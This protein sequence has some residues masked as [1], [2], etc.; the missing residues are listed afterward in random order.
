MSRFVTSRIPSAGLS[1]WAPPWL[2]YQLRRRPLEFL[3]EQESRHPIVRLGWAGAPLY[4][5]SA[6][7]LVKEMLNDTDHFVKG[8][9]LKKL[10]I[11]IGQGLITLNGDAWREG[12]RRVQKVFTRGILPQQHQT[13]IAHTNRMIER[14]KR[15]GQSVVNLDRVM[16]ELTF[17]IALDLFLGAGEET[18][19]DMDQLQWAIDNLNAYAKW[20]TWSFIPPHWKTKRNQEFRRALGIL[21]DVV[22]NVL[23]IRMAESS[24][25]QAGR[26]DVF[27]LLRQAGFEGRPLRDHIM[28]ILI[29]G[30]E[31]TGTSLSFLWAHVRDRQDLQE[32]L[33]AEFSEQN[34]VDL[35]LPLAEAIW[36]ETLRLYPAVPILDR[37]AVSDVQLGEHRIPR[38]SNV[39]WSPYVVQRSPRYWPQ[40]RDPNEFDP[41]AFLESPVPTPGSFI[42]FGEGPRMCLGKAFADMEA[43]T[44]IS[45]FAQAFEMESIKPGPIEMDTLVTLRPRGGVHVRLRRRYPQEEGMAGMDEASEALAAACS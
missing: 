12:R 26:S 29:A 6:P 22:A 28:T 20:R 41:V 33:V 16:N 2:L 21:D 44:I 38:G 14:L 24:A 8:A 27:S 36:K 11:I 37:T 23:R 32:R 43:L 45:L 25:E 40:R 39:L 9:M 7:P 5:V 13:V 1:A 31:T 42:P 35:N 3:Q 15:S 19:A 34:L 4:Y 17:G 30:H 18:I 10:E